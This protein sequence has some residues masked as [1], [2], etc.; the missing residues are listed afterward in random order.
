MEQY[1]AFKYLKPPKCLNFTMKVIFG[2][3][4]WYLQM[5]RWE[6][7]RTCLNFTMKVIFGWCI[8][9][10]QMFWWELSRPNTHNSDLKGVL[11]RDEQFHF[12]CAVN[13]LKANLSYKMLLKC[14]SYKM[15]LKCFVG[16]NDSVSNVRNL[17]FQILKKVF[18]K[19]ETFF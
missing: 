17:C 1:L 6:L 14:L 10:L 19:V 12:I 11:F 3:C 5:F 13:I 18:F 4:N 2:W 16:W 15:P 8:W 9:Y 7:S